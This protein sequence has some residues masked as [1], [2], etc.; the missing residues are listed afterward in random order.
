M[1]ASHMRWLW[2]FLGRLFVVWTPFLMSYIKMAF[3]ICETKLNKISMASKENF[4]SR[5]D[6]TLTCSLG[7]CENGCHHRILRPKLPEKHASH[8]IS[9]IFSHGGIELTDL[10]LCLAWTRYLYGTFFHRFG[11]TMSELGF[12]VVSSLASPWQSIRQNGEALTFDLKLTQHSTSSNK[13]LRLP[14]PGRSFYG[15]LRRFF[16]GIV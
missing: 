8:D 4:G 1:S 10:D 11:D 13:L 14:E 7:K 2:H 12:A 6:L 16:N 5:F 3:W 15:N 9:A